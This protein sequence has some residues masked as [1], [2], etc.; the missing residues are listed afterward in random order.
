LAKPAVQVCGQLI[1]EGLLVTVPLPTLCT[2]SWTGETVE[3]NVAVTDVAAFREIV[4]VA[5]VP[6][7]APDQS[8]NL[9]PDSGVA[10]SFTDVPSLNFAL[11]VLPHLIP[12]GLL[13]IVPAPAP[14][15]FNVSSTG[16]EAALTL[17]DIPHR[18]RTKTR[19]Q[20]P[21]GKHL[22]VDI[23][24]PEEPHCLGEIFRLTVASEGS[25]VITLAC[26]GWSCHTEFFR[27]LS[28]ARPRS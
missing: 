16:V 14:A 6:L 7:Q 15:L 17:Q 12:E 28:R 2:V 4:H 23:T 10:V 5:V 26:L 24:P 18:P 3:L 8:A 1:P 19:P 21:P 27:S 11:H 25:N 9:E 20:K 22:N 13:V